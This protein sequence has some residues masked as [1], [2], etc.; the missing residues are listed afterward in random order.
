[1]K[2]SDSDTIYVPVDPADNCHCCV[3]LPEHP[4]SVFKVGFLIL[5]IGE[6]AEFVTGLVVGVDAVLR[7]FTWLEIKNQV[8]NSPNSL[9][10][11]PIRGIWFPADN[12]LIKF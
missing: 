12:G 11:N 8:K 1:M 6:F 7:P 10:G 4:E 9:D 2:L 3:A 5:D